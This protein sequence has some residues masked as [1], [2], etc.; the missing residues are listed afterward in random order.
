MT[1]VIAFFNNKG[2]V[3]KTTLVYHLAWMM[4]DLG[5]SVLAVD[6]DPQANLTSVLLDEE[7]V[8]QI[9]GD[10]KRRSIY[11]ALAPLLEGEGAVAEPDLEVV[12]ENLCLVPGDLA[13][14]SVEQELASQWARTLDREVRAFRV[15]TAFASVIRQAAERSNAYVV[16]VDVGPNLGAI[17]RSAMVASDWVVVPLAPDLYSLQGLRNLGPTL[18]RWRKEWE[19]RKGKCP[20]P[21]LWL[22]Q[23]GMQPA[24]YVVLQHSVRMDRA[25]GAYDRWMRQVPSEYRAS[26]LRESPD[27]APPVENDPECLGLVKH[28]H[29]LIP[30]AQEARKPVFAL[31]SA[32]GAIGAHQQ[33]VQAAYQ[34]F[35]KLALTILEHAEVQAP[36]TMPRPGLA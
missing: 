1:S 36:P 17:N 2:G 19:E 31:R 27:N 21:D 16:L 32:D 7:R 23:G 28:Y 34:H 11:D 5:F 13:L 6:L 8:E 18:F 30:M 25:V 15:E 26:V 24:G 9:W 10:S 12:Q 14:S 4:A 20:R 33:A 3:G 35:Q 22:P 29:S